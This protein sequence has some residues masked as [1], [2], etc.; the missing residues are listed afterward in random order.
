M[1]GG[2]LSA[3]LHISPFLTESDSIESSNYLILKMS[4]VLTS[5]T[6]T[7]ISNGKRKPEEQEK[8]GDEVVVSLVVNHIVEDVKINRWSPTTV[9]CCQPYS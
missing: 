6:Y 8:E 1:A 3:R 5:I 7:G 2:P 4:P 9:S